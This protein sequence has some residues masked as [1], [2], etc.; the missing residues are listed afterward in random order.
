MYSAIKEVGMTSDSAQLHHH[1]HKS[2][3]TF[4]LP[5]PTRELTVHSVKLAK[6]LTIDSVDILLKNRA[7]P[8]PLH[9]SKPNVDINL[10]LC[11]Q[12]LD[13]NLHRKN[14]TY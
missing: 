2:C 4:L 1:V 5:K 6:T 10:L 8:L 7:I 11:S 12:L 3:F 9:L 13:T 14:N